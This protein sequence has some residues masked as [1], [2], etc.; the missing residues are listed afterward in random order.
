MG[1][2][3][4]G[5]KLRKHGRLYAVRFTA[6]G[7]RYELSTGEA[8]AGRAGQAAALIYARITN[9]R[10]STRAARKLDATDLGKAAAQ[11]L[12]ASLGVYDE[13]TI[14]TYA[15]F[16]RASIAPYFKDS[17]KLTA[18]NIEA[19]IHQRLKQVQRESVRKELNAIRAFLR[20]L[21]GDTPKLP[22]IPR[23]AMG[24]RHKRARRAK[25]ADLSPAD[26]RKLI[27]SLPERS[28][29]G[30]PVRA[31]F[32]VA[33]ETSLRPA[34]LD[35]LSVPEHY[36]KGARYLQLPEELDKARQGRPLPLSNA[37]R[38]ALDS[39]CPESGIIF[40]KH[41]FHPY[42]VRAAKKLLG[43]KASQYDLRHARI[44]HWLEESGNMPGTQYL[45]GHKLV[46]TTAKY[47]HPSLRAAEAVLGKRATIFPGKRKKT[48]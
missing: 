19:W 4:Q 22:R 27:A 26:I 42:V 43:K 10:G 23:G 9:E 2:P 7:E 48:A 14:S 46:S 13:T 37:A 39:V 18:R 34:T 35:G 30:L 44:T 33:Y 28:R 21:T 24:T 40:G 29:K 8:D 31:R 45:A 1:R 3:T 11:W 16:F 36:R 25:A 41:K 17:S 20:W 32:I 15:G 47:A 12:N 6:H 38:K 5:W